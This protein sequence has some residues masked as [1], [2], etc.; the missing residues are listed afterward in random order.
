MQQLLRTAQAYFVQGVTSLAIKETSIAGWGARAAHLAGGVLDGVLVKCMAHAGAAQP[1][2]H[3]ALELV[4]L[5]RLE[6]DAAAA[7]ARRDARQQPL[8]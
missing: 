4:A 8:R 7:K 3:D 5:V 6:H 2:L 1:L